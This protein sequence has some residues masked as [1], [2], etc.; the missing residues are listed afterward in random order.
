MKNFFNMLFVGMVWLWASISGSA[1]P[2][3]GDS[4][5]GA[6]SV[7]ITSKPSKKLAGGGGF[8]GGIVVA[9]VV[10][11]LGKPLKPGE[12]LEHI[13]FEQ[14]WIN[15]IPEWVPIITGPISWKNIVCGTDN[16]TITSDWVVVQQLV[17]LRSIDGSD[18]I[19]IGML[20]MTA[21]E[22]PTGALSDVYSVGNQGYSPAAIGIKADGTRI[23]GGSPDQMVAEIVLVFQMRIFSGGTTKAGRDEVRSWVVGQKSEYKLTYK[24]SVKDREVRGGEA[25]VTVARPHLMIT[26]DSITLMGDE[27]EYPYDI[28]YTDVV[29][30]PWRNLVVAWPG[31]EIPINTATGTAKFFRATPRE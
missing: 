25:S 18:S 23:T 28:Q 24:V 1:Q 21:T 11:I 10:P 13:V 30:G 9:D 31:D 15:N 2:A 26:R 3:T 5:S 17:H 12:W 27:P 4:V 6:S 20:S 19:N 14:D 8:V 16:G 22:T 7:T 29:S